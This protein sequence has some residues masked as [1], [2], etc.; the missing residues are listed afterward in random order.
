MTWTRPPR[1]HGSWR[2]P[3]SKRGEV[4]RRRRRE[5]GAQ[6]DLT[7]ST[8]TTDSQPPS[9]DDSCIHRMPDEPTT[10]SFLEPPL[11]RP[12]ARDALLLGFHGA[13]EL[14]ET[15]T[16]T[17]TIRRN[18]QQKKQ[19]KKTSQPASSHRASTALLR[20]R[21]PCRTGAGGRKNAKRKRV[22]GGARA[23]CRSD[24]VPATRRP[25]EPLP[26]G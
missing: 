8:T 25:A 9:L 18:Q 4:L 6:P 15:T 19:K 23:L 7:D 14:N 12:L 22:Y 11:A 10:L 21:R 26:A 1:V 13:A 17:T 20:S 2:Q 24:P 5:S 3:Q 16:T